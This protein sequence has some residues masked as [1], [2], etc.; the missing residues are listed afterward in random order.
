MTP[1]LTLRLFGGLQIVLDGKP[2]TDLTKKE[3]ALLGYLAV[4]GRTWSRDSLSTLLWS[5]V[6]EAKARK[7]LGVAL[8]HLRHHLAEYLHITRQ[9]IGLKPN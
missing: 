5:E 7:S 9:E 1:S 8:T 3:Q 6:E 4:T 2:L